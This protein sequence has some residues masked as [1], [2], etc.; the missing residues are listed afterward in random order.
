MV[1]SRRARSR[2]LVWGASSLLA[3]TLLSTPT[4]ATAQQSDD[5]SIG[6]PSTEVWQVPEAPHAK[7]RSNP[8]AGRVWGVYQGPQDQ[9]WA[10]YRAATGAEKAAIG[11]IAL[12]PRT[13]WY[14]SWIAP[15]Q[16]DD[17]VRDYIRS[18]LAGDDEALVQL[19]VFRMKPWGGEACRRV[20]TKEERSA[21]RRWMRSLAEGIGDAHTLVE[22]QPD[23]PFFWCVP[24]RELTGRLL[25]YGTKLLSSLPNTSVYID[26]GAADWCGNGSGNDPEMCAQTLEHTG[27]EFA[28]GFALDSTHYTGP[29][30]NIRHGTRIVKILRRDG[31]GDKHFIIDTAKSGVPTN[32]RDMIPSEPGGIT[33]NARTCTTPTMTRCVTLGI[34]PTA[35]AGV[36]TWQLSDRD[37]AKARK[38]VDGFV[39]FG[40]PWLYN[41]AD[42]FVKQRA[43]DMDQST[44]YPAPLP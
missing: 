23:G 17:K 41:Q 26:A 39:W 35:R 3:A 36:A 21:Y 38:W 13:K 12:R 37:R 14:G 27:I 1:G 29:S 4:G 40:R 6:T 5:L 43:L 22:M 34:P 28:R 15:N 25:R 20:P 44:K 16:I 8:L 32:W 18:S 42:P 24:N 10:P 9:V 31:Y 7:N 33:D 30:D 19:A 2:L 11:R